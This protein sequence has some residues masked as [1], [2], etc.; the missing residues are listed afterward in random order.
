M[1]G[2]IAPPKAS[3]IRISGRVIV[4]CPMPFRD[5]RLIQHYRLG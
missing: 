5:L 4:L 2:H 1:T 3:S